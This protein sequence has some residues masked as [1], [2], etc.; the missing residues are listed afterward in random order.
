[1]RRIMGLSCIKIKAKGAGMIDLSK[2][3]AEEFTQLKFSTVA[4][5][6]IE[7]EADF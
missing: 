4:Q 7:V 3:V 6:Q 1:M 5:F 2:V